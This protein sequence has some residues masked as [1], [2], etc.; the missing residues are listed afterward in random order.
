MSRSWTPPPWVI[1]WTAL[2]GLVVFLVVIRSVLPPFVIGA[3]GAYVFS[4]VADS[5]Q[6]RWRLPRWA[7]VTLLYVA[8]LGPIIIAA[9]VFGPRLLGQ[10]RSLLF[11]GPII[12]ASLIENIVGAGPYTAFGPA[13]DSRQL[14]AEI[15][16]DIGATFETP[17]NALH[18]VSGIA[19]FA[20]SARRDPNRALRG[21]SPSL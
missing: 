16:A 4:P 6:H 20:L 5:I 11:R 7:A 18:L 9:V 21:G 19:T 2:A 15:I 10:T 8:I 1:L 17:S 3:A 13:T 14:A 12:I